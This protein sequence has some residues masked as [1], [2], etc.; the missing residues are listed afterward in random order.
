LGTW[1]L[2]DVH[3]FISFQ[4]WRGEPAAVGGRSFDGKRD[5]GGRRIPVKYAALVFC[6]EF[7]GTRKGK[8]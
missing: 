1:N 4:T 2:G 8:V 5:E 6:E 7:N 3:S